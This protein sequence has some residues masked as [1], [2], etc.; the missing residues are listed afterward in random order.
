MAPNAA[1]RTRLGDGTALY[2]RVHPATTKLACAVDTPEHTLALQAWALLVVKRGQ[3][4]SGLR[5]VNS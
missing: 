2:M 1:R 5:G 4:A 3:V